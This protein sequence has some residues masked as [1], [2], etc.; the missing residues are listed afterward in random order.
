MATSLYFTHIFILFKSEFVSP[1]YT[2]WWECVAFM[3]HHSKIFFLISSW[4]SLGFLY[5][6]DKMLWMVNALGR[7]ITVYE[8]KN[9]FKFKY[10]CF[11]VQ[12]QD[13]KKDYYFEHKWVSMF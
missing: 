9:I 11:K 8:Y 1:F 6:C 7:K 10:V 4:Y 13:G 12:K 2:H 3:W 5:F